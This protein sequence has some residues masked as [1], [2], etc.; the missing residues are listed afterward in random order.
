[1]DKF[2]VLCWAFFIIGFSVSFWI[3]WCE[4]RRSKKMNEIVAQ[5][6]E[7]YPDYGLIM[8]TSQGAAIYIAEDHVW[9]DSGYLEEYIETRT[10]RKVNWQKEGF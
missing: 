9:I 3:W 10:S 6:R 5:I 2:T 7:Q 8:Y 4:V 1:M